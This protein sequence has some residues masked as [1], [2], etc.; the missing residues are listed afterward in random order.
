MRRSSSSWGIAKAAHDQGA[1]LAFTYQGDALKKRVEPLVRRFPALGGVD[2]AL[3]S[4]RR[5]ELEQRPI[6]GKGQNVGRVIAAA[7]LAV[8]ALRLLRRDD[9]HA[10]FA[11]VLA[12]K[13]RFDPRTK[14]RP[15]REAFRARS[16]LNGNLELCSAQLRSS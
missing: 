8:E 4:R 7:V 3:F 16:I 11:G 15:R 5:V 2:T 9:A 13:R 6:A 14:L 10:D 1:E 12:A